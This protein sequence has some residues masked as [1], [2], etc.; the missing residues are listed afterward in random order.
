MSNRGWPKDLRGR[1]R[2]GR[3]RSGAFTLGD[4]EGSIQS[5]AVAGVAIVVA[6]ETPTK[7]QG[8]S[9]ALGALEIGF[10]NLPVFRGILSFVAFKVG[11]ADLLDLGTTIVVAGLRIS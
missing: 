5:G 7:R 4:V 11:V 9:S 10:K 3:Y 8:I 2:G 6:I 1:C